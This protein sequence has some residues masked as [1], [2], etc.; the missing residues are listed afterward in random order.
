MHR[1]VWLAVAIALLPLEAQAISR[2]N[3]TSMSC[4]KV[5]AIV[6]SEGAVIMRWRSSRGV[7]RYGR[8]VAH[9]G[10][11]PSAE[12]AE[13]SYIPS[14]DRSSCPVYECKQYSPEDEFWWLNRGW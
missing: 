12:I 4:A 3:S 6:R 9:D 5:R 13:W 11:C 14:A 2:Y 10:F 1:T 8:F 7:Q